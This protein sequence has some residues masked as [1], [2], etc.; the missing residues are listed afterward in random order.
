MGPFAR[1]R[2]PW[3]PFGVPRW[4]A[5]CDDRFGSIVSGHRVVDVVHLNDSKGHYCGRSP[6][7]DLEG[8]ELR[9][10]RDI[11]RRA[12]SSPL[13]AAESLRVGRHCNGP[14]AERLVADATTAAEAPVAI[15]A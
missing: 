4:D 2:A 3:V 12:T 13:S 7:Y 8:P 14:T 11:R 15:E 9:A 6:D 10:N 5:V 1:L